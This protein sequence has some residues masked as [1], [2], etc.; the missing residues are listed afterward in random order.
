MNPMVIDDATAADWQ[1]SAEYTQTLARQREVVIVS[2]HPG[3]V[4]WLAERGITGQV[5]AH[6][7]PAEISGRTVIGPLPPVLAATA[8]WYAIVEMPGL[9]A[10]DRGRDLTPAEMDAAGAAL[11][12]W[13]ISPMSGPSHVPGFAGADDGDE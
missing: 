3:L 5:I 4:A 9:R 11:A 2:R 6:A 12:W 8:A 10:E 1:A 13:Q 7:A